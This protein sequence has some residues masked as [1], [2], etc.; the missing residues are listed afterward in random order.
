LSPELDRAAF[1]SEALAD[2]LRQLL[3][4]SAQSE[5]RILIQSP[6]ALLGR[7]HRLLYL[8]RRMPT[9]VQIRRLRD[10]PDWDSQTMV[11]CDRDSVLVRP[12]GS[13]ERAFYEVEA[14][15][16]RTAPGVV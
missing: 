1:D 5:V 8:A 16:R 3:L 6:A 11:I 12:D 10:H 2:A 14:R 9:R 15:L 13:S 4:D 7:G